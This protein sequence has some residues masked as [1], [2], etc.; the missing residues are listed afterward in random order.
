MCADVASVEL[1]TCMHVPLQGPDIK[2]ALSVPYM[3]GSIARRP[4]FGG[5]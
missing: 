1:I 4:R 5:E 3:G 2:P